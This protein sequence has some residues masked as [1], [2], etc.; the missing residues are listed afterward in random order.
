MFVDADSWID[1]YDRLTV[2]S[3]DSRVVVD[4]I[5]EE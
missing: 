2:D 1:E 4:P 3:T 5:R